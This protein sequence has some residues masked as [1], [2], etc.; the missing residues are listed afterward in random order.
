MMWLIG[1]IAVL[2]LFRCLFAG[3]R[4]TSDLEDRG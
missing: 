2:V 4:A 1:G 3:T